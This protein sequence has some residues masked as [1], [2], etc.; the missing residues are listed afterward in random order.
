[1]ALL[2]PC[3]SY[4]PVC[5][6]IQTHLRLAKKEG[7]FAHFH[8]QIVTKKLRLKTVFQQFDFCFLHIVARQETGCIPQDVFQYPGVASIPE[9][10]PDCFQG[11]A[12][13]QILMSAWGAVLQVNAL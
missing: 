9:S 1:M 8:V 4:N 5:F 6:R 12:F 10:L 13:I 7:I 2:N 11:K 3:N